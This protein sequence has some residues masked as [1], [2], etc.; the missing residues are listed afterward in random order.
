MVATNQFDDLAFYPDQSSVHHSLL[1]AQKQVSRSLHSHYRS[2]LIASPGLV[3][4]RFRGFLGCQYSSLLATIDLI[5]GFINH[6]I[7]SMQFI[8]LGP[9]G[10]GKGTQ[11][12]LLADRWQIPHIST[13]DILREAIAGKTALGIQAHVHVEAGKRVPD[14]LV[15]ALMR[16]RF[17]HSRLKLHA[18]RH[19]ETL[20][21]WDITIVPA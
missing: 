12:S 5:F 21:K 20:P 6:L 14:L 4:P 13:S 7:K 10:A 16:E 19:S 15:M 8:F 9:P 18:W 1:V 2:L 17:G 3:F 11:A